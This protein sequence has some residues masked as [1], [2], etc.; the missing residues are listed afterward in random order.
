MDSSQIQALRHK[1][2]IIA[3]NI[4]L[5]DATIAKMTQLKLINKTI[6]DNMKV[7]F[8]VCPDQYHCLLINQRWKIIA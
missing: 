6:L 8:L 2:H 4:E 3:S 5:D 1:R 7:S